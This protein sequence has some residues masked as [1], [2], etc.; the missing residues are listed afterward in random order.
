MHGSTWRAPISSSINSSSWQIG[1]GG[2]RYGKL[3]WLY[4]WSGRARSCIAN[5]RTSFVA[6]LRLGGGRLQ[7][8]EVLMVWARWGFPANFVR[9]FV[10]S[11]S[12]LAGPLNCQ[13]GHLSP[14]NQYVLCF[15]NQGLRYL[16]FF[17]TSSIEMSRASHCHYLEKSPT[18]AFRLPP[19]LEQPVTSWGGIL[20]YRR[21]AVSLYYSIS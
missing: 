15:R 19:G 12:W 7:V 21:S 18:L 17:L 3:W 13:F 9:V 14:K 4:P 1:T 2:S 16:G 11:W 10:A 6:L 20:C 8:W 5:I